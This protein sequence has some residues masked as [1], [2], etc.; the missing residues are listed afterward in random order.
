MIIII[1][2]DYERKLLWFINWT[3]FGKCIFKEYLR[4]IV[5]QILVNL[6][7]CNFFQISVFVCGEL[8]IPQGGVFSV[9]RDEGPHSCGVRDA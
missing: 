8:Y 9:W 5:S 3:V 7:I 6:G 1:G 2:K 4:K